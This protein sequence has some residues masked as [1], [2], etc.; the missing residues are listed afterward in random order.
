MVLKIIIFG[1]RLAEAVGDRFVQ[2]LVL[3]DHDPGR[4]GVLWS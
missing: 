3:H 2:E 1:S 4:S